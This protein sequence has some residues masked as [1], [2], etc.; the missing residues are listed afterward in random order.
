MLP[1][2][3]GVLVVSG[4]AF[5]YDW[6]PIMAKFNNNVIIESNWTVDIGSITLSGF[7][8]INTKTQ[9]IISG[10]NE[11]EYC[12]INNSVILDTVEYPDIGNRVVKRFTMTIQKD[13]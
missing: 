13:N 1:I 2:D 8:I 5:F 12:V 11:G 3:L 9:C 10:G 6:A 7:E 4:S